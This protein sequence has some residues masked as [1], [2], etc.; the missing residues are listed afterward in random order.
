MSIILQRPLVTEKLT[1]LQEKHN[2]YSFRVDPG[3]TKAEIKEEVEKR[4]PNIKVVKVNTMVMPSKPKGRYTRSGFVPG[5]STKWK[6]AI[7]TLREGDS[8]DFFSEI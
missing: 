2:Q 4:Y 6:K 7:V 8:I 1:S 5:R 3:I